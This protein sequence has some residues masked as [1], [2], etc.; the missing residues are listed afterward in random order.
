[1]TYLA[2]AT[3]WERGW[4]VNVEGV[5]VTQVR[6]LANATAQARDLIQ[7]MTD[8]TV[9]EGDVRLIVDLGDM[10]ERAR[11]VA[12]LT[13]EAAEAQRNAAA[14][15]R[16]LVADLRETN[17]SVSDIATVLGVSRGRVSQLLADVRATGSA[18]E[19][20]SMKQASA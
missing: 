15:S 9:S 8:A 16:K 7:T 3:Q 4:E 20:R 5:G 14:A 11:T 1:M 6:L 10:E 12:R 2:R 18:V 19:L 17:V 13:A